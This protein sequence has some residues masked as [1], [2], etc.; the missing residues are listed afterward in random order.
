MKQ[1]I[2]ITILCISFLLTSCAIIRPPIPP[3]NRPSNV[4]FVVHDHC[5]D[6]ISEAFVMS[7]EGF[8]HGS[9][10][11]ECAQDVLFALNE[12]LSKGGAQ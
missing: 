3:S 2:F 4:P 7:K 11:K 12:G 9:V 8:S 1:S 6:E 10:S 5:A